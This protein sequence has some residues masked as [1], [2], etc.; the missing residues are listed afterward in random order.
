MITN[1]LE[2]KPLPVYGD[3]K[4]IR[5]WLFV[6]DHI[7]AIWNIIQKGVVGESYAIGGENEWQNIKLL[8]ELCHIVA[9]EANLELDNVLNTITYVKDRAGHDKRYAIDCTKIKKELGWQQRV[10]FFEGLKK[11]VRWYITNLDWICQIQTANYNKWIDNNY[12]QR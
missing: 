11:T 7:E 12:G 9:E 3:G 4:N 1:I 5:D 10:T 6:E 8:H 2:K